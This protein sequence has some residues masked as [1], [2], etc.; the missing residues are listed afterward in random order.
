ML[1]GHKNKL[2]VDLGELQNEKENLSSFLQSHL[3][4]SVADSHNRLTV[5]SAAS[6]SKQ[7]LQRAVT[8]FIYHKNLNGTHWAALEN[9]VVKIKRFERVK[10]EKKNRNPEMPSMIKHGW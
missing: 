9:N 2:Q 7:E 10:K 5:D 6:T 8:K 3:Q 1:F 4:I